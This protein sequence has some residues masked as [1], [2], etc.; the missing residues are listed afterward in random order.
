[1]RDQDKT[2]EQLIQ[3]LTGLRQRITELEAD[4][5]ECD[6]GYKADEDEYKAVIRSEEYLKEWA[7]NNHL[8]FW[9]RNR[10]KMLYISPA[11]EELWGRS[12]QSLYQDPDSFLESIHP[13][14]KDR[15]I[16]SLKAE[17]EYGVPFC[18]EYRIV[19]PDGTIKWV[20]SRLFFIRKECRGFRTAGIVED[21]TRRKEAEQALRES[22]EKFRLVTET[23]EDVF[24]ISTPGATDIHYVS[25]GY[26]KIWGY[27][28]QS[29]YQSPKA[30]ID[31]IHPEDRE[32]VFNGFRE[33]AAGYASNF[34]YRI[35]RPDGTIRWIQNR[36]FPIRDASGHILKVAGIST[37]ITARKQAEEELH[38]YHCHLEELVKERTARLIKAN[39]QLQAEFI[40]RYRAEEIT[41]TV[42]KELSQIFD[43]AVEGI[44]IIDRDHK[45][46]RVNK[47]FCTLL[48]RS[49]DELTGYRCSELYHHSACNTL[50]CPIDRIVSGE[51]L[52]ESDKKIVRKDGAK[53]PCSFAA[54]PFRGTAGELLGIIVFLKDV[55]EWKKAEENLRESEAKYSALVE[56]AQD[57][58]VIIQDGT[59]KFFNM[60]AARMIG[61]SVEELLD[62]RFRELI[63]PESRALASWIYTL[64]L[65]GGKV[66]PLFEVKLVC[67][68]G[69]IK[70]GE[71]S[72]GLIQ[73]HGKPAVM[74]IMRDI[75]GR[76][77]IEEEK[78]KIQAQLIQAQKMEAIGL[79]A[80]GVAHDFNNLL[81]MIQGHATLALL[82]I[83]EDDPIAMDLKEIRMA[84]GRA[85]NLTRQLLLFS[86]KQPT[87]PVSLNLNNTVDELLKMIHRV[88]GE[89]ITIE[90]DQEPNLWAVLAD[91]G[92]IEQ[93]I[94]NLAI[95]ARDAMSK[96]GKL[97]IRTRNLTMGDEQVKTA[98]SEARAGQFVCLSMSDTGCGMSE[99]ILSRA[100]EP[101]FSTK[102]IGKGSGL[103]LSVVYGIIKQHEGW[104]DVCS[105]PGQ[106]S[107]F[108]IY[109]PASLMS[110]EKKVRE[111]ASVKK[112]QGRGERI[113]LVEDEEGVRKLTATML[114]ENGYVV[115]TAAT[116]MDAIS[117][118]GQEK[119]DFDLLLSDVVL[120]DQTALEVADQ[121]LLLRPRLHVILISGYPDKRSQWTMIQQRGFQFLHKPVPLVDLLRTLREAIE[122][123]RAIEIA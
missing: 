69:S 32:R 102:E 90:I 116:A 107:T 50:D 94:M 108:D 76:K 74:A 114:R 77:R 106:G 1:M 79:L 5:D 109:L 30:L 57:A 113:L 31:A 3:E 111:S 110:P 95:N 118:F 123:D 19:M 67:K 54:I 93:V 47:A 25:P 97:M 20:L 16:K 9:L 35:V 100:F 58:V 53:I 23:I 119:G 122:P 51:E 81:T 22:E 43:G 6:D 39:E 55:S 33:H 91:E 68:D 13:E 45:Y 38:K 8:V 82:E 41:K 15:L 44:A 26:E 21:I 34:E 49:R 10:D 104:I 60:A 24:W 115:F 80:G 11:Y 89:D 83:S 71:V 17:K 37:D 87:E 28:V 70:Q 62:T 92:N 105:K 48:G 27:S 36:G 96:G 2:K 75:T 61:Y 72:S 78:E 59:V 7:E 18:E 98:P 103:G 4:K 88:I 86:R 66:P 42:C 112:Y 121:L 56:H 46:L 12:C 65:S 52:I 117:V 40:E 99:D 14:D 29:L 101:F 73:Y 64:R 85:A 63:A 84:A 120:P